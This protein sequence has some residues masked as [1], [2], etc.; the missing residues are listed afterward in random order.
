MSPTTVVRRLYVLDYGLFQVHENGR[1]IGIPGFLIQTAGGENILVDTG[2]PAW[3]AI[4]PVGAARAEGLDSFGRVLHLTTDNLPTG[5][6]VRIGLT[7]SSITHLVMTHTDIDHVGGIADFPQAIL[8]MGRAERALVQPRYFGTHLSIAWPNQAQVQ[9]IDQDYELCPGVTLL[10]TPGH[11]PGHLSLLVHLP[12]TGA[13]ILTGDAI[14][15]PSELQEGFGGAWDPLL[16]RHQAERLLALAQQEQALVI[17]GHDP[18]QW[19]E[20]RKAPFFYA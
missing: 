5:Q 18:A 7:H 16:A 10:T 1:I 9:L 3:Y 20:L 14:S 19:P 11:S 13:V 6:L 17:Y 8:I 15:R 12:K 2:F 4:D